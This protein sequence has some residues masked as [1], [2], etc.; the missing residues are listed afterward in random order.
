MGKSSSLPTSISNIK[1]NFVK[2]VKNPKFSIGP[3]IERPGPI[4]LIVA[5]TEVKQVVVSCPSRETSKTEA[6]KIKI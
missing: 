2:S 6:A 1:T 4:L 5:T 3:T